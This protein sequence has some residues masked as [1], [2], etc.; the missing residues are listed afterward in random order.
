MVF[1]PKLGRI[2][3]LLS[4]LEW[5]AFLVAEFTDTVVD[6]RENFPL[7]RTRT[8]E[9]ATKLGI[10]HPAPYADDVVM[11]T[12]LLL[13]IKT[14]EGPRHVAW[15]VMLELSL[16]Q[17]RPTPRAV[18]ER[19]KKA[20]EFARRVIAGGTPNAEAVG[21]CLFGLSTT[22]GFTTPRFMSHQ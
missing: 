11:T 8:R 1:S 17:K 7:A 5:N 14:P 12:D 3:H 13:T 9:L 18:S 16:S 2:V 6:I 21:R 19:E 4:E 15:Y 20:H 10:N 22:A